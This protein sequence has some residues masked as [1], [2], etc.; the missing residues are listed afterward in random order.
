[1][2]TE[3][4]NLPGAR[5]VIILS[6]MLAHTLFGEKDPIGQRVIQNGL[7]EVVG[8]VGDVRERNL[9]MAGESHFYVPNRGDPWTPTVMVRTNGS[10]QGLLKA[11]REVI[12]SIDP[13]QP[14]ANLGRLQEDIGR[15]LRGK[16]AMLGLVSTF[17]LGALLLGC[18]GVYGMMAFTVSQ[19]EREVGIRM[20]L[21]ASLSGVVNMVFREGM[22]PALIGLGAGLLAAIAGAR[23][24]ESLLFEVTAYDPAVF[25]TIAVVLAAVAAFACWLPARRATRVDPLIALRAE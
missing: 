25:G 22:R 24:I 20:A 5:P 7:R 21:G 4:D 11:I 6:E 19:R 2:F 15:T 23:L 8:V 14:V 16:L 3:S 18:L 13:D 9:E 1:V 12:V 17:A 10:G